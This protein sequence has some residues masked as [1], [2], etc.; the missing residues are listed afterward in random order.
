MQFTDWL[1]LCGDSADNVP[2]VRG[3]GPKT[4]EPL[5]LQHGDLESVL[6]V[7]A[8]VCVR[9]K[10]PF[11]VVCAEQHVKHICIGRCCGNSATRRPF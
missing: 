11:S 5:L 4:A 2:G 7:A 1:A 9:W 3:I 8:E 10:M 6:A